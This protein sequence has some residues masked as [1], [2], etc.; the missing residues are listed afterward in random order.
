MLFFSLV[1][2][3]FCRFDFGSQLVPCS[4]ICGS[5]QNFVV[6]NPVWFNQR[7]WAV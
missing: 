1:L 6:G 4:E 5:E 7:H 2:K 3:W